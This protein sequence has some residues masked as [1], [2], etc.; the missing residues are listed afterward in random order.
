MG[1]RAADQESQKTYRSSRIDND[2]K[3]AGSRC[4]DT[5]S[6]EVQESWV[7]TLSPKKDSRFFF[8]EVAAG[9]VTYCD[10]PLEFLNWWN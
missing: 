6:L 8:G 10:V 4:E 5:E 3:A 7:Q 9:P 2:G 1:R